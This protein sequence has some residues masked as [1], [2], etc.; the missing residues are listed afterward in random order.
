MP[1]SADPAPPPA[2]PRRGWLSRLAGVPRAVLGRWLTIRGAIPPWQA[3]F[4][5]IV[6]VALC[7]FAWWYVTLGTPEER[8]VSPAI[9]PS[10]GDTFESFRALWF[11]RALTRNTYISLRRVVLGFLLAVSVGIPLGVLAGCFTRV[12]AFLAPLIIFGR[13][14]PLAALIP[15]TYFFFN[16]G[17]TQKVM[18]IFIACVA[19]VVSDASQAIR[20]VDQR[21]ID[22]AYTL[23]AGRWQTIL[24]VLVPLAMPN[25]F[26]S[27]RLLFGL[28][29]GYIMLAELIKLGN[30]EG[31]LGYLIQ[32]SQRLGP[33][34]HIFLILL[35]IPLIAFLLDRVLYWMQRELFPHQY[36]GSGILNRALRVLFHAWDDFKGLFWKPQPRETMP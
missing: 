8:I 32:I 20:D 6:C 4:L 21:Y 2:A 22:T 11:D 1:G 10:L 3:A 35:V 19:F 14:I 29:F 15:L 17:E 18:F 28:A 24:K 12:E 13:N 9:L 23:G 27:L 33:R 16:I 26:N 7:F 30:E 25:I 31:G 34:T 36:G 5:G